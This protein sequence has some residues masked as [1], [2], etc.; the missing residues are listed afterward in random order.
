MKVI[1]FIDS[2]KECHYNSYSIAGYGICTLMPILHDDIPCNEFEIPKDDI[3]EWCPFR[4]DEFD[5]EKHK[6]QLK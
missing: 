2:C 6:D 5:I 3:A 1:I 4:N